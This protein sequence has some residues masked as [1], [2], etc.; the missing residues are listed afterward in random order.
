MNSGQNALLASIRSSRITLAKSVST[1]VRFNT[2]AC[3]NFN[4]LHSKNPSTV[5]IKEKLQKTKL[6]KL[7]ELLM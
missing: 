5:K 1:T 7:R 6:L 2:N 3:N 4:L